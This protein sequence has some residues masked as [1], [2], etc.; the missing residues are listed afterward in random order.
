MQITNALLPD[1]YASQLSSFLDLCIMIVAEE[2]ICPLPMD[3][4][5]TTQKEL[6]DLQKIKSNQ[7]LK[8]QMIILGSVYTFLSKIIKELCER[9]EDRIVREVFV[10]ECSRWIVQ[11]VTGEFYI[12]KER[13]DGT[14][15]V[16]TNLSRVYLVLGFT[17]SLG[18][19]LPLPF[20][21]RM[22]ILPFKEFLSYDRTIIPI[23]PVQLKR[24]AEIKKVVEKAVVDGSLITRFDTVDYRRFI[25]PTFSTADINATDVRMMAE[26]KPLLCNKVDPSETWVWKRLGYSQSANPNRLMGLIN[27]K[28]Q[29][30]MV[31][32]MVAIEPSIHDILSTL[33][34]GIK[35]SKVGVIAQ[36]MAVDCEPLIAPLNELFGQTGVK[37]SFYEAASPE[38][39]FSANYFK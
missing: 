7:N 2:N 37:F 30:L 8:H 22:T 11:R 1:S 6:Q 5:I 27:N 4:K 35:I 14:L 15:V 9:L 3:L 24:Q 12:Y 23:S 19:M 26:L 31:F 34:S 20:K 32:Q 38:E 13:Q 21:A 29:V 39:T 18:R 16:S 10:N 36:F 33:L 17:K 25:E 28:G